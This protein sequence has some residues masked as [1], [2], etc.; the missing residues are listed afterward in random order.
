MS[1]NNLE[2]RTVQVLLRQSRPARTATC[3]HRP[4]RLFS[5]VLAQ[6]CGIGLQSRVS[7][8]GI[9]EIG[10]AHLGTPKRIIGGVE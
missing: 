3:A 9:K 7:G 5:Q 6:S 8:E 2:V 1:P 4:G 10:S